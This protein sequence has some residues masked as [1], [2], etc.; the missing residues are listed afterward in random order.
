M[1]MSIITSCVVMKITIRCSLHY[2]KLDVGV[3]MVDSLSYWDSNLN[4]CESRPNFWIG[5]DDISSQNL[6]ENHC[7]FGLI[8]TAFCGLTCVLDDKGPLLRCC[9]DMF[10]KIFHLIL[11]YC[12]RSCLGMRITGSTNHYCFPTADALTVP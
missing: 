4:R 7:L 11:L 6:Y 12:L 1:A 2:T 8:S 5:T 10:V 3:H 9:R